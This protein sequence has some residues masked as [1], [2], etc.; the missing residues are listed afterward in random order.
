MTLFIYIDIKN[1]YKIDGDYI[2]Y[3]AQF[4]S[5]KNHVYILDALAILKKQDIKISV[6]FSG[7]D[8]GNLQYVL[9]YAKNIG[10]EELVKYIGFAPNEEIYHLYKQSFALVMPSYFGPTNIC[11]LYTSPSPRD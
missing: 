2:Y 8:K 11:L 3:P 5:H 10:I 6:I 9:N 1:K 7:S 4:W